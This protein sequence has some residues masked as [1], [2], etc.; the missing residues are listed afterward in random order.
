M[1][2]LSVTLL[3]ADGRTAN[4]IGEHMYIPLL[5]RKEILE[6]FENINMFSGTFFFYFVYGNEN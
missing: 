1:T 6:G 2:L 4:E 3:A 5:R